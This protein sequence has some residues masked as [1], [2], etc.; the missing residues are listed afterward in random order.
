MNHRCSP[1]LNRNCL[2]SIIS[3]VGYQKKTH[4]FRYSEI[5]IQ[6]IVVLNVQ[7]VFDPKN[8]KI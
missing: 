5:L 1:T 4:G 8:S 2:D 7:L 6:K 3:F